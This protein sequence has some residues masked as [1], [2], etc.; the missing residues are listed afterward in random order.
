MYGYTNQTKIVIGSP[1]KSRPFFAYNPLLAKQSMY[2]EDL[3]RW[4][5]YCKKKEK[6][7]A[8]CVN[9]ALHWQNK[10]KEKECDK[11]DETVDLMDLN[12][13]DWEEGLA[14]SKSCFYHYNNGCYIFCWKD[15][16]PRVS[17]IKSLDP[18]F[19]GL[20]AILSSLN[21]RKSGKYRYYW[22]DWHN[23]KDEQR[24][25]RKQDLVQ[26]GILIEVKNGVFIKPDEKD[27]WLK[28][29]KEREMELK[30]YYQRRRMFFYRP[31]TT[32]PSSDDDSDDSSDVEI[33]TNKN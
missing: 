32:P 4:K 10:Q 28:K 29:E 27:D 17:I 30:W 6:E 26:K 14:A 9:G 7:I 1:I 3:E 12:D 25:K 13:V 19:C 2:D 11:R 8:A 20:E 15:D 24:L 23:F 16:I 22:S 5:D 31:M 18:T 33:T 21:L